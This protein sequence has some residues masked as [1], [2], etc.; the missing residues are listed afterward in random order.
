MEQAIGFQRFED[1]THCRCPA[2]DCV[3]IEFTWWSWIPAHSPHQILMRDAF[4]VD[5][6][7]V[8]DRVVVP[9]DRVDKLVNERVWF[10]SEFLYSECHHF[11]EERGT[12]H[13]GMLREPRPE[14]RS[15]AMGLRH[16]AN[17]G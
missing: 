12:G 17:A 11:L 8:R 15:D 9:D 1:V 3:E 13:I 5:K 6:H 2:L 16:S 10:K 4:V 7:P 14:T